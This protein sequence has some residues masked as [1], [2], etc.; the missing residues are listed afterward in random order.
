MVL[1]ELYARGRRRQDLALFL[2]YGV[3][4]ANRVKLFAWVAWGVYIGL[5]PRGTM[6][7]RLAASFSADR[8][9]LPPSGPRRLVGGFL[10]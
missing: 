1:L 9:G 7:I 4:S 10:L 3:A 5:P 8:W 2:L 6:V